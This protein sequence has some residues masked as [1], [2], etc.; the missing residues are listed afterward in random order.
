MLPLVSKSLNNSWKWGSDMSP[1][2]SKTN[3]VISS[4]VRCP[5][6]FL[7]KSL[8]ASITSEAELIT[9][10]ADVISCFSDFCPISDEVFLRQR[11]RRH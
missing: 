8:K 10:L 9:T 4:L 11:R 3:S 5:S 2:K 1:P 7:S 6:W